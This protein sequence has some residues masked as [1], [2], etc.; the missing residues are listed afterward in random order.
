MR[1]RCS[2]CTSWQVPRRWSGFEPRQHQLLCFFPRIVSGQKA[3]L[4]TTAIEIRAQRVLREVLFPQ[5]RG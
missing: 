2:S 3:T 5:A 1:A 4:L